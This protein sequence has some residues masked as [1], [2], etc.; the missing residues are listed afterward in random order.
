MKRFI[1]ASLLVLALALPAFAVFASKGV[2]PGGGPIEYRGL[3]ITEKGVNFIIVNRSGDKAYEF[4]AALS[5]VTRNKEFADIFIEKL[6]LGPNEQK[7][8]SGLHLK[9]DAKAAKKA[10]SLR[11]TVYALE[12]KQ[13]E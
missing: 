3:K 10:E 13:P 7:Q 6:E 5:F 4:S 9:G 12:E 11:W 1:L 2:I 8:L